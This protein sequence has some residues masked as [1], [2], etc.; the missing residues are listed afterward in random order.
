MSENK[1]KVL[2]VDD[3]PTCRR[4]LEL[5]L[6]A[7][8]SD[9]QILS[10]GSSS[11]AIQIIHNYNISLVVTDLHLGDKDSGFEICKIIKESENL[12]HIPVISVSAIEKSEAKPK[13]YS[14]IADSDFHFNK[15]F[16]I[17]ELTDLV[18]NLLCPA[19]V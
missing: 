15:P 14:D 6:K 7:K 18:K 11:Q 1:T 4:V 2:I 19:V 3:E 13:I 5:A 17:M 12:R 8:N 10:A 16:N 9:F